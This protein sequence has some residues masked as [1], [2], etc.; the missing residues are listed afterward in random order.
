MHRMA[1]RAPGAHWTCPECGRSFARANQRDVCGTWT[2]EQHLEGKP[3]HALDLYRRFVELVEACGP[4]AYAPTRNQIGFQVRRIFAGV[5]LTG[6]GL[7][8]YLDL[9]RRVE[10][11]RFR[12]VAPYTKHLHVH[13]FVLREPAEL[14]DELAGWVRESYA[15]G[16]GRHLERR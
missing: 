1:S 6:R 8:G 7:E 12:H 3:P 11:P 15:V 16:E 13:H 10:S 14:D 2:V 9:A 5:R 4:F